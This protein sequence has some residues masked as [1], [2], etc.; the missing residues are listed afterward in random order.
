VKSESK[1]L[2]SLS[3]IP[4]NK[5]KREA[6]VETVAVGATETERE[7]I[8]AAKTHTVPRAQPEPDFRSLDPEERPTRGINLRFNDYE[9][10]MLRYLAKVDDRSLQQ[11]IK[12]LLMPAAHRAADDAAQHHGGTGKGRSTA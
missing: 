2:F 9:L 3:K 12:R 5:A 8:E 10:G 11:T 7:F 4:S 6:P 1:N